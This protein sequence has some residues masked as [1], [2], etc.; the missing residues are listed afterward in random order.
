[1]SRGEGR[2]CLYSVLK[3][4][5][6]QGLAHHDEQKSKPYP[7]GEGRI[8]PI[9]Q[10][11]KLRPGERERLTW[12]RPSLGSRKHWASPF[13]ISLSCCTFPPPRLT[14]VP[15]WVRVW[16]T[17]AAQVHTATRHLLQPRHIHGCEPRQRL[18]VPGKVIITGGG[19]EPAGRGR[20]SGGGGELRPALG[21]SSTSGITPEASHLPQATSPSNLP[22]PK[23]PSLAARLH[24][25]TPFLHLFTRHILLNPY[26]Q[27]INTSVCVSTYYVP[28]TVSSPSQVATQRTP[29]VT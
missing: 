17:G 24:I 28:G 8:S 11:Q 15:T 20:S 19:Q 23:E 7:S 26:P 27:M 10:R 14:P 21:G 4:E 22:I 3:P 2:G 29:P 5:L 9:L 6:T 12:P 18:Q 16:C 13:P 25:L 1:M